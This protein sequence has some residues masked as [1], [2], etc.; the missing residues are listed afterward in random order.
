MAFFRVLSNATLFYRPIVLS[1]RRQGKKRLVNISVKKRFFHS[2]N[3]GSRFFQRVIMNRSY[4]S[5]FI[6]VPLIT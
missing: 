2:F 3:H 6:L 4:S 1:E 5:H